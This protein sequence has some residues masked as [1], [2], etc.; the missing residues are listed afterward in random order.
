MAR[1]RRT[2]W[3]LSLYVKKRNMEDGE[4]GGAREERRKEG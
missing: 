2:F 1:W 4:D 3:G